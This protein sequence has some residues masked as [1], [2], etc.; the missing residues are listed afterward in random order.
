MRL[1]FKNPVV[2]G[3]NP[4]LNR[5]RVEF[6]KTHAIWF[7]NK[8]EVILYSGQR[9]IQFG[10]LIT[11]FCLVHVTLYAL[12]E[13][14]VTTSSILNHTAIISY[15]TKWVLSQTK[16]LYKVCYWSI[17]THNLVRL[18]PDKGSNDNISLY[19]FY[20]LQCNFLILSWEHGPVDRT[21]AWQTTDDVWFST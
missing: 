3:S 18:E 19:L 10:F 21:S 16:S 2:N 6:W 7:I 9:K 1:W 11:L 12:L 13:L 17:F 8:P 4:K 5:K 14:R 20:K 15:R